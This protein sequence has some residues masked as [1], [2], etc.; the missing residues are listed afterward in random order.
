M[1]GFNFDFFI[2]RFCF[3]GGIYYNINILQV[4]NV[5]VRFNFCRNLII[6]YMDFIVKNVK[7]F[8]QEKFKFII[9]VLFVCVINIIFQSN[10]MKK[11]IDMVENFF[12]KLLDIVEGIK[13][14]V[15]FFK[16]IIFGRISL[17]KIVD[18][19]IFVVIVILGKV[20]FYNSKCE[21]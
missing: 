12:N 11:I 4:I 17:K 18:D 19:M 6:K 21:F 14:G 13:V 3:K 1:M 9:Y 8:F 5:D 2:V 16:G 7:G 20:C 15:E 10:E